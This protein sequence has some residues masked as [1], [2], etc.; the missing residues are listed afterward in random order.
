VLCSVGDLVE[1]LV[2]TLDA[3]I[4]GGTDTPARIERRR[5]GSAANVAFFAAVT[6]AAVRF[7]GRVGSDAA[8]EW[9]AAELGEAGVDVRVQ[10]AGR[11]G[12]VVVLVEP[13]GERTMLPDRGA[14]VELAA[15]DPAWLGGVTWLHVPAYSLVVDPIGWT[16]AGLI[17]AVRAGGGTVSVDVSSVGAVERFGRARFAALLARLDPDVLFANAAEAELVEPGPRLLVVKDGPRPV[18]LWRTDGGCERIT[19]EPVDGVVD[20]TGAGDAFAA[21]F[22]TASMAGAGVFA[23]VE[24]GAALAARTLTVA[25]AGLA[26]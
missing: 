16:A 15:V 22:I 20:T 7:V 18:T 2:V 19:I 21:G 23:A 1:D 24:S 5:G 10:R 26:E 13:G 3:P 6:G 8:G 4:A 12:T 14:A 17:E 11:T 9:L 25:G